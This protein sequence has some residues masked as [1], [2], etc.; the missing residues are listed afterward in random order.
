MANIRFQTEIESLNGIKY[1]VQIYDSLYSGSPSDFSLGSAPVIKFDSSGSEKFNEILAS[2]CELEFVLE[3]SSQVT[4]WENSFRSD[5]YTERDVYVFIYQFTDSYKLLWT[6][7]LLQDL[8]TT[9]DVA[10]PKSILL[11]AVD[12]LSV[13]KEIPFVPNALSAGTSPF[14]ESQ[15]YIPAGTTPTNADSSWGSG[16]YHRMSFWIAEVLG[17]AGTASSSLTNASISDYEISISANWYNSKMDATEIQ[18]NDTFFLTAISARQFYKANEASGSNNDVNYNAMSCYDALKNMLRCFG[19][20][21]FYWGHKFYIIQIGLYS[22]AETGTDASP[23]NIKTQIYNKA[24]VKQ[25]SN[26]LVGNNNITRYSLTTTSSRPNTPGGLKKLSGTTYDDF[27]VYKKAMTSFTSVS[28]L[29]LFNSFVLIP[30]QTNNPPSMVGGLVSNNQIAAVDTAYEDIGTFTDAKDFT[31]FFINIFVKY[32]N[33]TGTGGVYSHNNWTIQAKPST[34]SSWDTSATLVPVVLVNNTTNAVTL[35]WHEAINFSTFNPNTQ[36]L[37]YRNTYGKASAVPSGHTAKNPF[38]SKIFVDLGVTIA[39]V[40]TDT[41]IANDFSN[42]LPTS[43]VM[44]GD[45]DF[46]F[47]AAVHAQPVTPLGLFQRKHRGHGVQS[48]SFTGTFGRP[49]FAASD[50]PTLLG[51]NLD[52]GDISYQVISSNNSYQSAFAVVAGGQIGSYASHTNVSLNTNASYVKQ[53][54]DTLWGD[55]LNTNAPGSLYVDT[56]SAFEFTNFSGQWGKGVLNGTDSL[57]ELLLKEVLFHNTLKTYKGNLSFSLSNTNRD[58]SSNSKYPKQISP[59]SIIKDTDNGNRKFVMLTGSW[60]LISNEVSGTWF[61]YKYDSQTTTVRSIDTGIGSTVN[62]GGG[63]SIGVGNNDPIDIG[64]TTGFVP[65][66]PSN[67]VSSGFIN[68]TSSSVSARLSGNVTESKNISLALRSKF[69]REPFATTTGVIQSGSAITTIPIDG[70]DIQANTFKIGDVLIVIDHLTEHKVEIAADVGANATSLSVT[71]TTFT[72]DIPPGAFIY[73]DPDDLYVQYQHKTRGS[74]GNFDVTSTGMQSG[75]VN[76]TSYIDDDSFGTASA[77]SL[78]TSESIKA[79]V[80]TQVSSA[81]TLQEVTDNGNTTTNSITF[82]GGTSTGALTLSSTVDQILILKSTDDGPVYQSYY[83]GSDRHAYL[84]FGGSND[85]FNIVNEESSGTITFGTGGSERMRL[86]SSGRLGIGTSS[87]TSL[88]QVDG[89]IFI[90]GST[91]KVTRQSVTNYYDSNAMNSYGTLYDWEFSG[92]KVMRIN[93]SGNLLIGTTSDSGARLQSIAA[94]GNSSSLRIGRADNSNFWEFNHAGNDLRIYNEATSGSNILLGVDAGGNAEANNVGIGT[95]SPGKPLHVYDATVNEIIKIESG[96]SGA[97]AMFA[98]NNTTGNNLIGATGNNLAFWANS[99]ERMR[100]TSGGNVTINATSSSKTLYVNGTFQSSG[101]AFFSHFDNISNNSRMRDNLKLWYNTNRTFGVYG[102]ASK[103]A[104]YGNSTDMLSFDTSSN[105]TFSGNLTASNLISNGYLK[106][107]ADNKILSDGSVEIAIDYNNNQTDRVFKITKDN[108]SELFRV[109]EDGRV[110][111][112]TSNPST[113]LEVYS[114]GGSGVTTQIK[115]K[116][117][118]DGSGN[119]GA[120]AILQSS[121][122]GEAYLKLGSHQVSAAGGDMNLKPAGG[123]DLVFFGSSTE[124][125]RLTP[126]GNL[127]IGTNSPSQKLDVN[128][129]LRIGDGGSGSNLDFNSTDRGVIKINGSE[130]MRITSSG[131]LLVNKTTDDTSNKLQVNG[132]VRVTN[133]YIDVNSDGYGYRFGAG[134]CEIA[135]TGFNMTFKNWNGSSVAENMRL[136]STGRLGIGGTNPLATLHVFGSA[137]IDSYIYMGTGQRISWGNGNQ[138]ISATN[139]AQIDFKTGGSE[140]MRLDSSG[141][142]LIG[143]TSDIGG[144]LQVFSG[145]AILT[146]KGNN[147]S[148]IN[149][150]T[151]LISGH[152]STARGMGTFAYCEHSDVE[153][154]WGNP[155]NGNDAFVIN[156][157]SGYTVPSSQSSPPG[158]GSSQGTVL[159][160]NSSGNTTL[161]GTLDISGNTTATKASDTR[162]EA[163][164]TTAGAYF[165]ANSAANNYFGLELYHNTTAKWFLGNYI[166]H[167]SLSSNDFAIVSGAKSNGN[168]RLKIDSSGNTNVYGDLKAIDT[169]ENVRL[170]LTAN[171]AYNSIIYFGDGDSS[172]VGRIQYVHANNSLGFYTNASEQMRLDSS[173]RLLLNAT[174]TSFNDTLY[175]NGFGYSTNGWRVGT[176][177][178]F[179]GYMYNNSGKLTIESDGDRDIQFQSGNNA[180]IMYIDTS[181]QRV[182]I[183]T[184][185]PSQKLHVA[186]GNTLLSNSSSHVRLYIRSSNSTQSIIY[187]GDNDSST[188]GRIA[189]DNN[190][191]YMYFHTNGSHKMR[192]LSNGHLLLGTTVDSGYELDVTGTFRVTGLSY[193]DTQINA[194]YGVKFTNGDTDFLLYNNSGEDV[195]YMRDTTNGAMITTWGVNDFTVN[196]DLKVVSAGNAEI[197]TQ[198]TSGAG[199]LI[200]SQSATGVVGTSTNHNLDLKT[201]GSTRLRLTT[202]GNTLL[203]T[204]TDAGV[205]LYVNGVIRAV[206]GGI[207][208]AQD[209]GFTL[210]DESGS[211]RYGLKFGAAGT[212]GGSNLLMLTNRSFNSATGG[213]EVAIGGNTNTSGVSEVE[214]ARFSPRVT[215]TSGTQKKVSLDAVL[216]LSAQTTPADPASGKSVIWMDSGGDIKVKI[217]VAGTTVTRTIAAYE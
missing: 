6:G 77:N 175:V 207:Q 146:L 213:G 209:Y 59:L 10:L 48:T 164:A 161:A 190:G 167:A 211:N 155:Y 26:S 195:L 216:E 52:A 136:T 179:V 47:F 186:E 160:I 125:M 88:L 73:P 193:F 32:K 61:E 147:A 110:G 92:T 143:T 66:S 182:G 178:T 153:W 133:N 67:L 142:L 45:W 140:S 44:S 119:A 13:L 103:I 19:A 114:A 197:H 28:N 34:T 60:N 121:G 24:G 176:S 89:T 162:I 127:G 31:G 99:S 5:T 87:P 56:G 64:T 49:P 95:A 11:Q 208:A 79:Y 27:P 214:I 72:E 159:T 107:G 109:Q 40:V 157:N 154:F 165:R 200:Q 84:G 102:N 106:I 135:H 184:S 94:D 191:D 196:K 70:A 117:A 187:F 141:R 163:K 139:D 46:R 194:N 123:S 168:V 132:G 115:V 15:T 120:D 74:I 189:Y 105:A 156:R 62:T 108:S 82:A 148:Y 80:D 2:K 78:A 128:G 116:Q 201:N 41:S 30:G 124:K 199:V 215:A 23:V 217:N 33:G 57:T 85:N 130:K 96:D 188:Q 171:N 134:D 90:N 35:E 203:G 71:N 58:L 98:D 113:N 42:I 212:V 112:G 149:A 145:D 174:S 192:L 111:I 81:D 205:R 91:L 75:S 181:V 55:T 37:L 9:E 173:G 97:F 144:E 7:Y 51:P 14:T 1:K 21:I 118:D 50:V 12:G 17:Y 177:A 18:T 22:S 20:R 100:I 69:G 39:N 172:T 43:N 198:R 129:N 93:S 29:N 86:D 150:A 183:G 63:G 158:I 185:T 101:E 170:Y 36:T 53:I 104:I 202:G 152:A 138:E 131:N 25:S 151:Q 3:N 8:S 4:F 210:N 76:I 38:Q 166:D 16:G 65:P 122:W 206:G 126:A 54:P 204:T 83:R 137:A 68:T 169:S 180:G